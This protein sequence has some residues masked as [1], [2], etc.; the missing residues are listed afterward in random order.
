MRVPQIRLLT[1]DGRKADF[2]GRTESFAAD[3]ALIRKHLGLPPVDELPARNMTSHGHWRDYYN[4]RT[5][6]IVADIFADDLA[7]FGYRFAP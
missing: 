3:V 4:D 6:D 1:A 2:I 5:R 7:E